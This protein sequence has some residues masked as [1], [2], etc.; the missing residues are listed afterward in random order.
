MNKLD[1]LWIWDASMIE[2]GKPSD[3]RKPLKAGLFGI[4]IA[5]LACSPMVRG[6]TFLMLA[7][8]VMFLALAGF[9]GG[10]SR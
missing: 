6:W 10:W 2:N 7:A 1:Q 5:L 9:F 8:G 3:N 4:G